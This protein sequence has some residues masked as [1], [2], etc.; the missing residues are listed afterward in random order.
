MRYEVKIGAKIW[1]LEAQ[2]TE[3][4]ESITLLC[5]IKNYNYIRSGKIGILLLHSVTIDLPKFLL[6]SFMLLI[7]IGECPMSA[8]YP[9]FQQSQ[10][11]ICAQRL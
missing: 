8:N 2:F 1:R 4:I 7:K 5:K 11:Y 9:N 3:L 10:P 6:S